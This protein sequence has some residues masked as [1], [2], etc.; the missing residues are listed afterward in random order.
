[1]EPVARLRC[2]LQPRV[3]PHVI[4]S[5]DDQH[6]VRW[7]RTIRFQGMRQGR[8]AQARP[9]GGHTRAGHGRGPQVAGVR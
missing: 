2:D 8:R 3:R 6:E 1:M 7:L 9:G 5:D 4:P